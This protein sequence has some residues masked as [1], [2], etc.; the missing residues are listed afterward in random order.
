MFFSRCSPRL[1]KANIRFVRHMI[2]RGAGDANASGLGQSLKARGYVHPVPI[3]IASIDN[4]VA[5][6]YAKAKPQT[7]R[8]RN[9][10]IASRHSPLDRRRALNG[11]N[12]ARELNQRAVA[13]ELDDTATELFYRRIDQLPTA[14]LQS[15]ECADLIFPHQ[16]AVANHVGSKYRGKPSL[17]TRALRPSKSMVLYFEHECP[18]D[19]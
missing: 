13:H 14:S 1:R 16:A 12:D 3:D 10:L 18:P 17:H 2:E 7:S 9:A 5:E 11:I 8:F 15:I 19:L 4:D 6:I